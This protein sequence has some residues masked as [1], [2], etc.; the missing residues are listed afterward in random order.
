[1]NEETAQAEVVHAVAG[2]LRVKVPGIRNNPPAATKLQ[3]SFEAIED[4]LQVT[5]N[6][7]T[8][9]IVIRYRPQ[10]EEAVQ[11]ALQAELPELRP[12]D[13]SRR[14]AP[15]ANGSPGSSPFAR[16]IAGK[17]RDWNQQVEDRTAL[18]LKILVPLTLVTLGIVSLLVTALRRRSLP[19][20]D[21]YDLLWFAF[22]TFV[23][24]NLPLSE[25]DQGK[26]PGERA[27][28]PESSR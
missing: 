8:T 4:V 1:M 19:L 10:A 5:A 20:P 12:F 18:D 26:K 6:P 23:I 24:F 28:Q 11:E 22:N 15:S 14:Y 17:L 9:S 7:R 25:D 27:E 21:W 16:R 13:F 3:R 2:R